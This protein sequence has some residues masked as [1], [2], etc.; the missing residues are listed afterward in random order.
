MK[1][2]NLRITSC[3]V[4]AGNI[5]FTL[6][7][8][9]SSAVARACQICGMSMH[10][11]IQDNMSREPAVERLFETL[12]RF[13]LPFSTVKVFPMGGGIETRIDVDGPVVVVGSMSL[14]KHALREGWSPGAWADEEAFAFSSCLAAHGNDMLNAQAVECRFDEVVGLG[15]E[16]FFVRPVGDSKLFT[17]T[18]MTRSVFAEWAERVA[19]ADASWTMGPDT[20]VIVA[21]LKEIFSETRFVVADGEIVTGS[22]YKRG[23]TVVYDDAVSPEVLAWAKE[24]ALRWTPGRVCVMDV[25]E[26]SEGPKIV[27]FNNFNSAGWY[28]CDVQKIVM[29]VEGLDHG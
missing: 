14:V 22:L 8:S 9:Q 20:A 17:G 6:R 29:A 21:P 26:T 18:R 7:M 28:A 24:R 2:G 12:D 4:D 11:I 1:L 10:W 25:A 15:I 23:S 27:E 3:S 13:E 5:I 19:P 16:E